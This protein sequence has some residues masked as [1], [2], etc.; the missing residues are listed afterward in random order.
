MNIETQRQLI[1]RLDRARWRNRIMARLDYTPHP[2]Q[3]QTQRAIDRGATRVYKNWGRQTG[4]SIDSAIEGTTEMA[5]GPQ[6]GVPKRLVE[7]TGPET[8]VTDR[9]FNYMWDWI[10][11][12]NIFGVRPTAKSQRQRYIEMPWGA[13]VEGKTTKEPTSLLGDGVALILADEHARDKD[14]ILD[15][16]LEPPTWAT[17]GRI[18][19]STTP[20]G[21]M[22]HATKTYKDW[23]TQSRTD[24][25]YYVSTASSYDNPHIDKA[26]IEK[27][28]QKCIRAGRL[29]L[30]L[31]EVM[32]EFTALA[33]AVFKHF[34]PTRHGLPWHVRDNLEPIPGVPLIAGA[35]WGFRHPFAFLIGQL[36]GGDRIR[37]YREIHETDL[38]DSQC[39]ERVI[40]ELRDF[41]DTHGEFSVDMIYS[42]PSR[43]GTITDWRDD[44]WPMFEPE[45][46]ERR[47]YTDFKEGAATMN[48]LF[49]RDD[50]GPAFEI[51]STCENTIEQLESLAWS[52]KSDS[53]RPKKEFDDAADACRY[54]IQGTIGLRSQEPLLFSF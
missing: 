24:G 34:S 3:V 31:Q 21:R 11:E 42:D 33:G 17:G 15:Q 25:S 29:D 18:I 41:M 4:K 30:F 54:K 8:D 39:K 50:H 2:K 1:H 27:Y 19:I 38:S 52:D 28:K 40:R 16:Y 10:V 32:A 9:I 46:D 49:S 23:E 20:Q 14:N 6:P 12:E 22:N 26:R 51:D 37:I 48:D 35:D 7:I 53:E 44:G 13:R 36:L 5:Y 45:T 43:P 47:Q